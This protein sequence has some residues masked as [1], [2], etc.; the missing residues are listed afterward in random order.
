MFPPKIVSLQTF[1]GKSQNSQ[2]RF[3]RDAKA[4]NV[5]RKLDQK[6]TF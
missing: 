3:D 1:G 5:R 6:E 2:T 4:A